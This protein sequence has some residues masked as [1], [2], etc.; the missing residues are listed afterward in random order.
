[1]SRRKDDR[2]RKGM[3]RSTIRMLIPLDKQSEALYILGSVADQAQFKSGCI[4]SR[5]YLGADEE[6][7]IMIEEL[8]A[9]NEE[10][11]RHWQSDEYLR[12]LLV[13]EMSE[14]PPE[15][16]FD[17]ILRTSG[18]EAIEKVLQT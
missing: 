5:L 4:S 3:V 12:V 16:R 2:L 18:M 17:E 1:M 6:R 13:I 9:N 15:I 8:W 7:A 14:A 10:L 11:R